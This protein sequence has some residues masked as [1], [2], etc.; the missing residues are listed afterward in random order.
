MQILEGTGVGDGIAIGKITV[1]EKDVE[2]IKKRKIT[3]CDNEWERFKNA[4]EKAE[5]ELESLYQKALLDVGEENAVLFRIHKMM[6]RD[7]DFFLSVKNIIFS[8]SVAP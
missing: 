4:I 8:E 5:D 1:W 2:T 3:D 6:L 7:N